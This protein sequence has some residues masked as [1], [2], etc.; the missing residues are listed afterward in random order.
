[1]QKITV[2]KNLFF[3]TCFI[4]LTMTG[5]SF[6]QIV[7]GTPS[8]GFSQACASDAFNSYNVT[9]VFSPDTGLGTTNQFMIEMSD[10]DGSFADAV[11]VFTSSP[12]AITTSPAVVSFQLPTNTGGENYRIR[13]K[14]T[15]PVATSS[16]STSFAAYYKLQDSPF[17]INNMVPTGA[18][19]AGSSYLLT[20]DNPGTGSNDS[21]LNYPSLTF[22]WFRETGPTTSVLVGQGN[23]YSVDQPG[24][25]FAETDY[26]SCTSDSFSN[27]VTVS[28]V[29]SGASTNITSS[30]G[31]PFCPDSGP[32]TLTTISGTSYQWYKDG[33]QIDGATSQSYQTSES[34]TYSVSVDLGSCQ[35]TGTIILQ[36]EGF[37]SSINVSDENELEEGQT[38]LVIV[39]T[40]AVDPIFEWF[41]NGNP[42][43]GAVGDTYEVS[44]LGNYQVII[45]QTVGCN[46]V[47]EFSF[48]VIEPFDPFPEVANIPNIVSPN[49]DGIN[50]TWVIP[51][52][53][54]SGTGTNVLIMTSQG[55]IVL[56]T[57]DYQNNW[58]QQQLTLTSINL[59]YYYIIT[60]TD[61]QTKKGSIT[62]IQ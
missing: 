40:N 54:V 12:G 18:Y 41:F 34:G 33:V 59:V 14:S 2:F 58:P 28:E 17:A 49:G 19:C 22:N 44:Q 4:A 51:T 38:L 21:P 8:L 29:A 61:N 35:A 52:Q 16:G 27:R 7:I 11:T 6:A 55:E 25:Y 56:Q 24:T 39:S 48:D 60:T 42:I 47:T 31:N 10:A 3:L 57:D 36:S 23:S 20:I 9:F 43:S 1:M 32:T 15:A 13:V 50:D 37:D 30:L 53:Y 46:V 45:T 62:I 5:K 26:G